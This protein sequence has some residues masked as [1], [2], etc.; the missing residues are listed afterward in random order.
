MFIG[1]Q[2]VT[3]LLLVEVIDAAIISVIVL[4]VH[5][6]WRFVDEGG[7]RQRWSRNGKVE[8]H[9]ERGERKNRCRGGEVSGVGGSTDRT[10][11]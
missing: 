9:E 3:D 4:E 5:G 10:A 11:R 7:W 2:S 6:W 1:L 8:R